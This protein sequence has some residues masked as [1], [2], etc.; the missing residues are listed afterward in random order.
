MLDMAIMSKCNHSIISYGTYSF[1]SAYLKPAGQTLY[2]HS[3][4][5]N[6]PIYPRQEP[7]N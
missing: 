6:A 1:W 5:S 4:Y 7:M 3:E 2:V